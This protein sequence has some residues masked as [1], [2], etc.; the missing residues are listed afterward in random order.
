MKAF[1]V[2]SKQLG[3]NVF[4]EIGLVNWSDIRPKGVRDKAY[5]VLKK[6]NSPKHFT[7]IT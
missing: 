5:L 7:D 1:M 3:K 2:I 4:G 6:A